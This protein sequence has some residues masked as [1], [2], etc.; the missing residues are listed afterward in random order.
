VRTVRARRNTASGT[1][2]PNQTT[3]EIGLTSTVEQSDWGITRRRNSKSRELG[4]R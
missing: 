2:S 1:S 3:I 4:D